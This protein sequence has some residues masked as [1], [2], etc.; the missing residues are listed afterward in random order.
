MDPKESSKQ[1]GK[2]LL[3]N[4]KNVKEY[5]T[6]QYKDFLKLLR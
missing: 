5:L 6:P 1:I 2:I 4:R 3:N